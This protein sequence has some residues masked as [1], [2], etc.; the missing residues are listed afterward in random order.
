VKL[1]QELDQE[2]GK[3]RRRMAS[4]TPGADYVAPGKTQHFSD[5]KS[6]ER[7]FKRIFAAVED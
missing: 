3:K 2:K 4:T 6:C 7:V 1:Y 5:T